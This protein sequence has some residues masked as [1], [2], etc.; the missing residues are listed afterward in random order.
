MAGPGYLGSQEMDLMTFGDVT[1]DFSPDEWGYLNSAQR[2]LYRD[3]MLENYRNLLSVG[4]AG[5]KPHLIAFLEQRKEPWSVKKKGTVTVSPAMSSHYTQDFSSVQNKRHS[6][7]KV[8]SGRHRSC[9][10]DD[11]HLREE[12]E[13]VSKSDGQKARY[14]RCSQCVT[15]NSGETVS[16]NRDQEQKTSQKKTQVMAV[17]FEEP[18]VSISKYP[19]QLLKQGPLKGNLESLKRGL[20]HDAINNLNNLKCSTKLNLYSE[21]SVDRFKN[22]HISKCDQFESSF[23]KSSLFCSQQTVPPCAKID[24]FNECGKD[25]SYLSLLNQNTETDIWKVECINESTQTVNKSCTIN[26]KQDIHIGG[27]TYEYI[28]THKNFNHISNPGKHQHTPLPENICEDNRCRKVFCQ[29]L[30]SIHQSSQVQDKYKYKECD[31][32]FSQ[33]SNLTQHQKVHGG[34]KPYKCKE[35]GKAFNSCSYLN[36]H[37]RIHT[38]EKPYECKECGK[39]F[40]DYSTFTYHQRI[41][42]GE[43]PYECKECGKTFNKRSNLRQHQRIH[44]G[45]KPYKCQDCGQAFNQSA[46]LIRHQRV[47]VGE[48]GK[49]FVKCSLRQYYVIHTGGKPYKCKECGKTF[50]H[51]S[52]LTQHQNIH[53]GEKPYKCKDCGKA[54]NSSL[55]LKRHHVIHTGEKPYKC[56]AC[57]KAFTQISKLTEHQRVHTGEKPYKCNECGKAFHK[58]PAFMYHHRTHTGEKPYECK[59]CGKAFAKGSDLR[60]HH[61]VHTGEKPYTCKECS[62]AFTTNSSLREHHRVHTGEKPYKCKQCSKAFSRCSHLT[63]HQRVH[64]G[65]KPYKCKECGKDF[66]R[67]SSLRHHHRIHIGEKLSM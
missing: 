36:V 23:T 30:K 27:K 61:R 18:Y 12:W 42:T 35:C 3:V 10:T 57:D 38:G 16:A 37:Q 60:R 28:E 66:S 2:K 21:I 39:A 29:G 20:V 17:T 55:S 1:I 19:H 48:C 32:T 56:K 25:F 33:S 52:N 7:P 49:S 4:L 40:I 8:I 58:W 45:E 9:S 13:N 24:N 67:C 50:V 63:V 11:S 51:I 41:H 54:F 62:K 65:E 26:N 15:T 64:T 34:E 44:T 47:Y 31:Q 46:H 6:S 43:K 53:T 5:S 59:E 22:E 14:S